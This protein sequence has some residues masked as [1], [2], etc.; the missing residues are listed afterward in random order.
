MLFA[1]ERIIIEVVA[2]IICFILVKFMVKPFQVTGETRYLGLPIG[3]GFLGLSY[4]FSTILYIPIFDFEKLGWIQLFVRGFAF[5]FLTI[6]YYFSR[7]SGRAPKQL[8][9]I[10]FGFFVS[11]LTILILLILVISPEFSLAD[12]QICYIIVRIFAMICL[13]YITIHGL[14]SH[15]KQ[16]DPAT[17]AIPL[18]FLLLMIEQY[19]GIIWISDNSYL[20]LYGGLAFRLAS[21]TIFLYVS[22]RTFNDQSRRGNR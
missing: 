17:L 13:G 6:T 21:L 2:A 8:F 22:Y 5:L 15:L 9:N 11:V 10:T 3:F 18:G 16:S 19:S 20:A 14:R 12:Y 1:L 7:S 4:T